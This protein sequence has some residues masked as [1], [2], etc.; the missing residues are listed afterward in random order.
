M[1]VDAHV[2]CRSLTSSLC[3]TAAAW[4]PSCFPGFDA[5]CSVLF[6]TADPAPFVCLCDDETASLPRAGDCCPCDDS[7]CLATAVSSFVECINL[8]V[9]QPA[10]FHVADETATIARPVCRLLLSTRFGRFTNNEQHCRK[11]HVDA[12]ASNPKSTNRRSRTTYSEERFRSTGNH[13]GRP[14]HPI[15]REKGP[16]RQLCATFCGSG[17]A[18]SGFW[19]R[20]DSEARATRC[21]VHND[22]R[23]RGPARSLETG[24]SRKRSRRRSRVKN[25]SSSTGGDYASDAVLF[26]QPLVD[27]ERREQCRFNLV[28]TKDAFAGLAVA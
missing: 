19:H 2:C 22:F 26:Q 8:V 20:Y 6:S 15:D 13:N 18:I 24:C 4:R 10:T 17:F 21:R 16:T 5:H 7:F 25:P 14:D 23:E 1:T 3:Q 9:S 27:F 28:G 12:P 11:A